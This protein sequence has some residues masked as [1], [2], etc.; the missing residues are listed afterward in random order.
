[1][2]RVGDD[3]NVKQLKFG[4]FDVAFAR[5]EPPLN[6]GCWTLHEIN[7]VLQGYKEQLEQDDAQIKE[8]FKVTLDHVEKVTGKKGTRA[9]NE[10]T[11]AMV[12]KLEVRSW[13]TQEEGGGGGDP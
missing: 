6:L 12:K 7:G 2:S 4:D 5:E 3:G 9:K 13:S 1:M 8:F 10:A 11:T